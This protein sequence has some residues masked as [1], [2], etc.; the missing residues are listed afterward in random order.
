MSNLPA[1]QSNIDDICPDCGEGLEYWVGYSGKPEFD[2]PK[3]CSVC[4][5][6]EWVRGE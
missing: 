6:G 1:T 3:Y 4:E 2:K 5:P